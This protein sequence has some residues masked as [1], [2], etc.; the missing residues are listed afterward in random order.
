MLRDMGRRRPQLVGDWL[1]PRVHRAAGVTMREAVK[2]L[3][4]DTLGALMAA[5]RTR[6][7]VVGDDRALGS[8]HRAIAGG[9]A[10]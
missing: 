4:P 3:P 6:S 7:T 2:H 5:Y 10:P 1:A 9:V 8:D